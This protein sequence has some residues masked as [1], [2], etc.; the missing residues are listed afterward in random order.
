MWTRGTPLPPKLRFRWTDFPSTRTYSVTH[1]SAV[2]A[3]S[4]TG[5]T[6]PSLLWPPPIG[7][8]PDAAP[9]FRVRRLCRCRPR[10]TVLVPVAG[11]RNRHVPARVRTHETVVRAA[12]EIPQ[13]RRGLGLADRPPVALSAVSP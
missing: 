7:V 8:M 3:D 10:D 13:P 9:A 6:D 1:P 5:T 11:D 2:M 12:V 4:P